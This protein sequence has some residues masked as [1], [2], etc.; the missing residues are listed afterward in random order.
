MYRDDKVNELENQVIAYIN[1]PQH[2]HQI[3]QKDLSRII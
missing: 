3:R 1:Y 2:H